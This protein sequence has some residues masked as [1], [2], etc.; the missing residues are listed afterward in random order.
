MEIERDHDQN[1]VASFFSSFPGEEKGKL[2]L[3]SS[4]SETPIAFPAGW[5][6]LLH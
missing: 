6:V 5:F 2:F 1:V 4:P 3:T